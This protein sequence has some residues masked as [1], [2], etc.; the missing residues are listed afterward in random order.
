[1]PKEKPT[2]DDIFGRTISFVSL[3]TNVPRSLG[4]QLDKGALNQLP[5]QLPDNVHVVFTQV[6]QEEVK[7]QRLAPVI[8]NIQQLTSASKDIH[9]QTGIDLSGIDQSFN[10]LEVLRTASA[11]FSKDLEDYAARCGGSILPWDWATA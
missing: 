6:V 3:D 11:K 4:F 8:A 10:A 7:R 1:M 5:N 9:R 2:A